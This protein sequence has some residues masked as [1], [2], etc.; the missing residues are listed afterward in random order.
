M[1]LKIYKYDYQRYFFSIVIPTFFMFGILIYGILNNLRTLSFNIY[2]LCIIITVYGLFNN[3]ISLSNPSKI[4]DNG[5][6]IKFFSFG[7][8]HTYSWEK[9]KYIRVREFYGRKIYLRIDNPSLIKGRYWIKTAMYNDGH[10]LYEKF[11]ELER[12]LHPNL[13]K[14]RTKKI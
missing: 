14:F 11:K 4:I 12:E 2:T 13:L 3:I 6:E 10:E 7:R 5:K 1:K 9:V 8:V